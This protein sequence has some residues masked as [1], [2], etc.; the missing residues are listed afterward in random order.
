MIDIHANCMYKMEK[1]QSQ[2]TISIEFGA[3]STATMVC[4]AVEDKQYC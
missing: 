2:T 1:L 4:E 3:A